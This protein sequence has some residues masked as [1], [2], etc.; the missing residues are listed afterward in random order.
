MNTEIIGMDELLKY[1]GNLEKLPQKVVNKSAKK[2]ANISLKDARG[3][4][5]YLSGALSG[6]IISKAEKTKTKGK[7]VYQAAID[8]GKNDIFQKI[9][10]GGKQYYY[11]ASQEYGFR[12]RGGGY[13]PGFHYMRDS[14]TSNASNIESTIV[15]DIIAEIDKIK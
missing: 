4:A 3:K 5:P 7:K 6:G 9:T 14:V 10:K 1:V 2:G 8:P 15:N 12:T 13:V 11:P